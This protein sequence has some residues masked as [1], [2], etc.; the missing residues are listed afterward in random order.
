MSDRNNQSKIAGACLAYAAAMI[1]ANASVGY[2][3]P[4]ASPI[5]SFFLIG[6]DLALRDWLHVRLTRGQMA[7]LI[8]VSGVLTWALNAAPAQIAMASAVSFVAAACVDWAVFGA[9]WRRQWLVRANGSN[10]ASAAVDSLLFPAL[11]FGVFLPHI[12]LLQFGAKVAGG[13]LWAWILRGRR[14]RTA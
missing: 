4:W 10:V 14:A 13:A 1:A 3:G 6:L 7:A 12:I 8:I 9:L 11:A 2:F 5:N